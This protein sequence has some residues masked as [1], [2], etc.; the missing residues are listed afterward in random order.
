MQTFSSSV[1]N[2]RLIGTKNGAKGTYI[3]NAAATWPIQLEGLTFNRSES[4]E[5][6]LNPLSWIR[7]ITSMDWLYIIVSCIVSVLL[8]ASNLMAALNLIP[9]HLPSLGS[10]LIAGSSSDYDLG[11]AKLITEPLLY[12]I[13]AKTSNSKRSR[14]MCRGIKLSLPHT[15]KKNTNINNASQLAHAMHLS[16]GKCC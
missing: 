12:S 14:L 11:Q 10:L 13:L 5:I 1:P 8:W 9:V 15:C 16:D 6:T 2:W 4:Y 3:N 7:V